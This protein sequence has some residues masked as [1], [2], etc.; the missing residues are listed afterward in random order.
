MPLG[1]DVRPRPLQF[2]LMKNDTSDVQLQLAG[3]S[4]KVI[5]QKYQL[6]S[7][8]VWAITVYMDPLEYPHEE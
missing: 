6:E 5:N 1:T 4:V 2:V 7:K 3:H 8:D